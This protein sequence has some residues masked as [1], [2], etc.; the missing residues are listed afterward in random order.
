MFVFYRCAG[1]V[2]GQLNIDNG[3]WD[4]NLNTGTIVIRVQNAAQLRLSNPVCSA[5]TIQSHSNAR[6][7]QQNVRTYTLTSPCTF[8]LIGPVEVQVT[9]N[10]NDL[11]AIKLDEGLAIGQDGSFTYLSVTAGNGIEDTISG[12]PLPAISETTGRQANLVQDSTRPQVLAFQQFDLDSGELML[13]FDEPVNLLGSLNVSANVASLRLQHHIST[14]S[15]LEYFDVRQVGIV[16]GNGRNVT[17]RL[18]TD[19]VNRLKLMRRVCS[20]IADCWLTL[21]E[22]FIADMA[23]NRVS[24]LA[25]GDTAVTLARV[26]QRFVVDDKGPVLS[27]SSLLMST[28]VLSLDFDEPIDGASFSPT[29]ITFLAAPGITNDSLRYQLTGGSILSSGGQRLTVQLSSADLNALKARERLATFQNNTYLALSQGLLNDLSLTPN[30]FQA[31]AESSATQIGTFTPDTL[32]PTVAGFTIDFEANQITI[33]WDE[34]I[35]ASRTDFRLLAIRS[36]QAMDADSHTFVTDGGLADNLPTDGTLSLTFNLSPEDLTQVKLNSRLAINQNSTFLWATAA[37][38]TVDMRFNPMAAI[39]ASSAIRATTYIVNRIPPELSSYSLDMNTGVMN[40]TFND[41][42][43][44]SSFRPETVTLQNARRVPVT[45]TQARFTFSTATST[46]TAIGFTLVVNIARG[47]LDVLKQLR[48]L[49]RNQS[50]TYLI[51]TANVVDDIFETDAIAITNGQAQQVARFTGDA[52]SPQV[53]RLVLDMDSGRVRI[54]MTET[55][56]LLTLDTSEIQLQVS[57][58]CS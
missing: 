29:A 12:N 44:G 30:A 52:T 6:L 39:P 46:Q 22:L 37:G 16:S 15:A 42:V 57:C 50:T 36:S 43:N 28:G 34:P 33:T 26:L 48:Q 1:S 25:N 17:I 56:D 32:A 21:S 23:G 54:E 51:M 4:L 38:A 19:E 14:V 49:A 47:D 20:S 3:G 55:V 11:D 9:L 18:P 31:I 53:S 27:A 5:F 13:L 2:H 41:A 7:T 45:D 58:L 35:R 8:S 40:M 10:T 24:P